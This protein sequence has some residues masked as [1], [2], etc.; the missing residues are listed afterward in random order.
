MPERFYYH[1]FDAEKRRKA[2]AEKRRKSAELT[3]ALQAGNIII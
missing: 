3:R 1:Y 2:E